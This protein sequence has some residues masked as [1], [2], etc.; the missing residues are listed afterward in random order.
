MARPQCNWHTPCFQFCEVCGLATIY[1][2]NVANLAKRS[3]RKVELFEKYSFVLATSTVQMWRLWLLKNGDSCKQILKKHFFVQFHKWILFSSS[4][5]ENL[6][7]HC[8]NLVLLLSTF[9][10]ITN[11]LVTISVFLQAVLIFKR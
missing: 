3:G 4:Q 8:V 6:P 11:S 10:I 9:I 1:K 7:K 5:C 2:S